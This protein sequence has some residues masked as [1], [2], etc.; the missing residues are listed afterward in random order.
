MA[1]FKSFAPGVEVLGEVIQ[2]FLSGFPA[3][4][5]DAGSR[6]LTHDVLITHR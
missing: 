4:L 5:E 2:A 3:G 6:I 1:Q